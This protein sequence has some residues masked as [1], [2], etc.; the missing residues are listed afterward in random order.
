MTQVKLCSHTQACS[1]TDSYR[2]HLSSNPLSPLQNLSCT[3]K[4]LFPI[5]ERDQLANQWLRFYL[6]DRVKFG[7]VALDINQWM[8]AQFSLASCRKSGEYFDVTE[9][10]DSFTIDPYVAFTRIRPIYWF[11]DTGL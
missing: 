4:I 11:A 5:Q 2:Y 10:H 3:L 7:I 1:L 6:L 8:S 9:V